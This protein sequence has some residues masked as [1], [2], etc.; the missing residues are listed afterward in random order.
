MNGIG[1]KLRSDRG[2]SITFALL[3]FL[4]CAV[5][6]SVVIVAGTAA[7][8]RMS[9][10]TEM[11]QRY[12]AVT[13]ATGL[14]CDELCGEGKKVVI[15]AAKN[16]AG[17]KTYTVVGQDEND[18]DTLLTD[19]SKRLVQALSGAPVNA[20]RFKLTVPDAP[21]GAELNC[22][23]IETVL[24]DGMATFVISNADA[25]GTAYASGQVYTQRVVFA[26]NVKKSVS[27]VPGEQ[28]SEVTEVTWKLNRVEKVR[29][30]GEGGG[31]P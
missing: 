30:S 28:P 29:V 12:Y 4:V 15:A 27:P 2:A 20:R 17:E 5:V 16:D 22:E 7:A 9:H 6:S 10:L 24:S 8:G 11:D 3:L 1:L 31:T 13:S 21:A 25:M 18:E 19:T 23:I 26:S 14:L